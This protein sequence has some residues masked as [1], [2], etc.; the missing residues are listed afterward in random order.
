MH[1]WI[2]EDGVNISAEFVPIQIERLSGHDWSMV[3]TLTDF[4][5]KPFAVEMKCSTATRIGR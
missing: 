2:K 4:A 5:K 1:F 3:G